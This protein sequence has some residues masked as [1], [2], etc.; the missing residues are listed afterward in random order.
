MTIDKAIAHAR[1]KAKEHE[2][3]VAWLEELKA[4]RTLDKTNFSDGYNRGIDDFK[5]AVKTAVTEMDD[6]SAYVNPTERICEI[7]KIESERLKAG[8]DN[9]R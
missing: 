7:L 3:L 5:E 1:E 4:Y 8:D 6:I 9:D 2:Q